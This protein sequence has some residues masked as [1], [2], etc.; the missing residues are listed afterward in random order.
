MGLHCGV[1]RLRHLANRADE[2][3]DSSLG[4]DNRS[5]RLPCDAAH[6]RVLLLRGGTHFNNIYTS[7]D[8]QCNLRI[9]CVNPLGDSLP[10]Y[11][12]DCAPARLG[13]GVRT[14]QIAEG[15]DCAYLQLH[16][17]DAA[18]LHRHLRLFV[19]YTRSAWISCTLNRG[20][21]VSRRPQK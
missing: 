11:C 5:L 9:L 6:R 10:D 3:P 19:D 18:R 16:Q 17:R 13:Q 8:P 1:G 14:R 20:Q 7:N 15:R 4:Y 12:S 21:A 2:H